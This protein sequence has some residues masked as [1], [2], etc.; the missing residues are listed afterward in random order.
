MRSCLD[1]GIVASGLAPF[2]SNFV[3]D[4]KQEFTPRRVR[5]S[6]KKVISTFSDHFSI[7][8]VLSNLTRAGKVMEKQSKGETTWNLRKEGG[9]EMFEKET[10]AVAEK[11]HDDSG[12]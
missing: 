12:G 6:K 8:V 3:V 7:E 1:L 11:S 5:R 10:E 2:V 4:S 9:W